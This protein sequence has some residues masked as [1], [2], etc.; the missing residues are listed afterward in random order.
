MATKIAFKDLILTLRGK[1][2]SV[3]ESL[4]IEKLKEEMIF[5]WEETRKIQ[6][7]VG[8]IFKHKYN[9]DFKIAILIGQRI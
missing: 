9:L 3:C 1:I 5:L 6:L 7:Y 8:R 4:G 2:R